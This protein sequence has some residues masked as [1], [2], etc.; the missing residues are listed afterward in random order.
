MKIIIRNLSRTTTEDEL[1]DLFTPFGAVASCDLV[2]DAST[3]GSKGFGF[4]DMPNDKHG[5]YAIKN[6]NDKTIAGSRIRVK[7]AESK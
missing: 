7:I 1:K 5:K 4:V 3:G 2:M 6:L